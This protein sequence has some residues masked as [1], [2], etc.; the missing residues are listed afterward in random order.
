MADV[1]IANIAGE[2]DLD[3]DNPP[4]ATLSN[5]IHLVLARA[6]TKMEDAGFGRLRVD[7]ER[8][9]HQGLEQRAKEGAVPRYGRAYRFSPQQPTDIQAK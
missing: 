5:Q 4:V 7:P 8:E 6:G 9:R 1:C 2:F 3:G